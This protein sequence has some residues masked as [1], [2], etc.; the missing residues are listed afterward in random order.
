[1]FV[2]IEFEHGNV[3]NLPFIKREWRRWAPT[4]DHERGKDSLLLKAGWP[5]RNS[6]TWLKRVGKIGCISIS[7]VYT[8]CTLLYR[9]P[10]DRYGK[11]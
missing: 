5:D 3:S 8:G 1:M 4:G 7:A 10:P 11:V 9:I 6:L 2:E